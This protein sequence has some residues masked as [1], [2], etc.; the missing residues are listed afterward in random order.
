MS[1]HSDP[2]LGEGEES[3]GAMHARRSWGFFALRALNDRLIGVPQAG[4]IYEMASYL[5]LIR[6]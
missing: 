4:G 2:E 5:F 1:C 6:N 3:P